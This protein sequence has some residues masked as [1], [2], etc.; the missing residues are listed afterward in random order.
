MRIDSRHSLLAALACAALVLVVG[1]RPAR[2][3]TFPAGSLVIPMDTT[4][5]DRGMLQAFGLLYQL[6]R[7]GVPV[8]W[9]I[10]HGKMHGD[11]D[12][13]GSAVDHQTR[14]VVTMH[15][16]RGGPFVID[17]ADAAAALPIIDEW[18]R[19]HVTTV[20]ELTEDVT[21]DVARRLVA[22]PN[23]AI[24]ADGNEGIARGYLQAAGIPDSTGS[25]AWGAA[26]PDLLSVAEVSGP[27]TTDHA[28]GALFDAAGNPAYCQIMSMHW[29][30]RDAEDN[31]E[32]VAEVRS[33][34]GNPVHFF[35]ECQAVNAFEN[36]P[37]YGHFLTPH[38]FAID[39]FAGP[40]DYLHQ[41]EP[42]AQIDGT[43]ELVGG[44]ERAYSPCRDAPPAACVRGGSY[45]AADIVMLTRAG[46][47]E[48]VQDV[49]MTGYLDGACPPQDETCG[50][51]GKISY[52]GGHAYS[53][54]LPISTNPDTQGTRLFLQSLFEAPCT[55]ATGAARMTLAKSA[56]TS[57][58]DA[59]ITYTLTYRNVGMGVAYAA[60]IED[61]LP[62]GATFVSASDG[63]TERGGVVSWS[64]GNVGRGATG[65]VTVTVRFDAHGAYANV[66]TL[67]YL[68]GTSPRAVESNTTS[69][70]Y[71][72][73]TDGD[74]V[75][76]L[77]DTCPDHANPM[78]DLSSD[79]DNCGACGAVCAPSNATGACAAGECGIEAC[80]PGFSDAD[81][82]PANGCEA[83]T[84]DGGG[85][86]DG[87]GSGSD[88]GVG[89][90]ADGST[91]G[92]DAGAGG[93]GGS[94]DGCGCRAAGARG[95]ARPGLALLLVVGVFLALRSRRARG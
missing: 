53:T 95:A 11:V 93:G 39:N 78:Q 80:D 22:A 86:S 60:T 34:L 83:A 10:R 92:A 67:R 77:V 18:Q 20:H 70:A 64:L 4:H 59:E 56:V 68:A 74:G 37:T 30:V 41:D 42:F 38:G 31:P 48:G 14:A 75:V 33:F 46:T 9:C 69:T 76:D 6:L 73:D 49:W 35:A 88:S 3:D 16:Y 47:P 44:S 94:S 2:A 27:T 62:S 85:G 28:D 32:V 91:A 52:L 15:G 40:V 43:F 1:A 66:A 5:Q 45:L 61:P 13:T 87:G 89:P 8:D 82:D 24:F 54:R 90:R 79:P 12:F 71:D 21:V 50:S 23:I 25:L 84:G 51:R 36:E 63:G 19:T 81:G 55:T 17:A 65:A 72:V 57:T 29:G 58:T 7:A 26:S